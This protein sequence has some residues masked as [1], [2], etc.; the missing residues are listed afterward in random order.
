M[1]Q[2]CPL[3]LATPLVLLGACR[4]ALLDLHE[5]AAGAHALRV[6]LD[7]DRFAPVTPEIERAMKQFRQRLAH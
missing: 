2:L 4:D 7:A 3:I 1:R 6:L 5:G